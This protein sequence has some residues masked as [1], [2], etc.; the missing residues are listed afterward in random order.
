MVSLRFHIV[1]LIAVFLALGVGIVIGAGVV[2]QGEVATIRGKLRRI[3]ARSAR[4]ERAKSDADRQIRTLGDFARHL[5]DQARDDLVRGRLQG[6]AVTLVAVRG[7]DR[8]SIDSIRQQLAA[9]QADFRGTLWCTHRLQLS[10]VGDR[11]ALSAALGVNISDPDTLRLLAVSRLAA[12]LTGAV[13]DGPALGAMRAQGFLEWDSAP[14]APGT[15]T[16]VSVEGLPVANSRVLLVSGAGAEVGDDQFA[17]PLAQALAQTPT[18]VVAA[19][20]GQDGPGG[21]EVFVGLLR[22][23]HGAAGTFSTV[24]NLESAAGQAAAVLALEDLGR[25]RTGDYGVAPGR[26]LRLLPA[27]PP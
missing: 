5:G 1:S 8:A 2:T 24:D 13:P 7:A 23:N 9:A 4:V 12:T 22:R 6:V 21:R 3:E 27:P 11:S 26:S 10:S 16:T 18:G 17:V 20:A 15:S 14:S 19:E 25:G